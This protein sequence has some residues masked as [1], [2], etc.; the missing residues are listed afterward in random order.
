MIFHKNFEVKLILTKIILRLVTLYKGLIYLGKCE[1]GYTWPLY[2]PTQECVGPNV[3]TSSPN[4][5]L[6]FGVWT[7]FV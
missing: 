3:V 7:I 6:G 5:L 2:I 1:E 4:Q